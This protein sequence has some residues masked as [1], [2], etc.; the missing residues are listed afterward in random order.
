MEHILVCFWSHNPSI[1]LAP[2]MEGTASGA[3]SASEATVQ[4]VVEVVAAR[5]KRDPEDV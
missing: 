5:F 2:V 1:S 3:E 4:D